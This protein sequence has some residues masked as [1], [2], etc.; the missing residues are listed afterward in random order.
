[1]SV[2]PASAT[3]SDALRR[4]FAV[5]GALACGAAVGVSAYA[6]HGLAGDPQQRAAIAAAMLFLHGLALGLFAPRQVGSLELA[7]LFG[8][9]AG[10]LLFCGSLLLSAFIGTET[11]LAPTGGLLLMLAWL[12]QA[13]SALRR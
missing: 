4:G 2:A 1:V 8:W 3:G 11:S 9:L 12:L 10:I 7:A 13:M 5:A 6:M